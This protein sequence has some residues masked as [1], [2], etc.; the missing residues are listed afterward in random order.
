MQHYKTLSLLLRKAVRQQGFLTTRQAIVLLVLIFLTPTFVALVMHKAGDG[1]QPQ[2]TTNRGALVHPARLLELPKDLVYGERPVT[3][4]LQGKWTLVYIG[5]DDCGD[6]CRNNLY[7]MRQA[8]TA[9]NENMK[10]VQRLFV[11][12]EGEVSQEL[13]DFLASEHPR[14]DMLTLLPAQLEQL[15]G[16]FSID[17]TPVRAAARI[18]IVD[19]LGNLMM[20]YPPEADPRG[21][22]RDLQKLLK[23][24]RIG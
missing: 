11:L 21:L 16:F 4:Y 2:G 24:S 8:R 12:G 18:Y 7:K 19:P 20:Y 10:R 1:W 6:V 13:A 23:Y 15:S 14:M 9:Q 17:D 22:L 3:D 5:A